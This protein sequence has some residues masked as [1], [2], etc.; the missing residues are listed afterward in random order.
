MKL[1]RT[2][3]LAEALP[4]NPKICFFGTA[5]GGYTA[6]GSFPSGVICDD[7]RRSVMICVANDTEP[8]RPSRPVNA[9]GSRV[10]LTSKLFAPSLALTL[11]AAPLHAQSR[12]DDLPIGARTVAGVTLNRDSAASII[13]KFG[14]TRERTMDTGHDVYTSLCYV[15]TA[16]PS[17]ALLELMSDASDRETPGKPL[18]GFRIRADLPL[19]DLQ[20][21][22]AL[23]VPVA[24][25]TPNGLRLGLSRPEMTTLLG[26]PT[27]TSGDSLI[28]TY[29]A[30]RYMRPGTPEY[31]TWSTPENRES[32]FDAGPPY[33]NVES[34]VL[35][36]LRDGRAIELRIERYDQSVC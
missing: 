16:D 31:E 6:S 27:R 22:A 25:A 7:L 32:C 4:Y 36:V 33:A 13:A 34:V 3:P 10:N 1:R 28:W 24:L 11:C 29:D 14:H 5:S 2:A 19:A 35:V 20:G 8:G 17:T 15:A 18:N 26:P 23:P 30:K 12:G 9:N 21:C